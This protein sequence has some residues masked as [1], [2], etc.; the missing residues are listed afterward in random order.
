MCMLFY[1][2]T[3]YLP[4]G[5]YI[6][7]SNVSVLGGMGAIYTKRHLKIISWAQQCIAY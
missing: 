3:A 7:V 2:C 6:N 1:G 5:A 4:T